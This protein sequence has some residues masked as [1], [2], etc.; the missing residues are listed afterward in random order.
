MGGTTS[1]KIQKPVVPQAAPIP[2]APS[3]AAIP[4]APEAI[5]ELPTI[6]YEDTLEGQRMRM[7]M[8]KRL[9][10]TATKKSSVAE[11]PSDLINRLME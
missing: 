6:S 9:Y 11:D 5:P 3:M 7:S 8:I 10:R 1:N 4:E 2:T